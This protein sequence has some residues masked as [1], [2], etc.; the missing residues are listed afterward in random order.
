M[1]LAL[2]ASLVALV[3]T[4]PP[5][6]AG[7]R[8]CNEAGALKLC[9]VEA[10]VRTDRKIR[11]GAEQ[12]IIGLLRLDVSNTSES[13]VSVSLADEP[14][15]LLVGGVAIRNLTRN[16]VVGVK[17]GN[18]PNQFV[19]IGPRQSQA[20]IFNFE[21][22]LPITSVEPLGQGSSATFSAIFHLVDAKSQ[23]NAAVSIADFP[24]VNNVRP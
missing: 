9:V 19:S 16:G 12:M 11:D 7:D 23:R 22:R 1:K 17:I 14:L 21:Q 5:V 18:R 4:A 6:R 20:V 10:S 8:P 15:Q 3:V 13:D 24:I 2:I